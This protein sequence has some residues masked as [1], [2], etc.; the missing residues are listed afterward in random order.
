M[1]S[2]H[3]RQVPKPLLF[4]ITTPFWQNFASIWTILAPD[5]Q[6]KYPRQTSCLSGAVWKV[7]SRGSIRYSPLDLWQ[8]PLLAFTIDIIDNIE[9]QETSA[10]GDEHGT[11]DNLVLN[12]ERH[13]LHDDHDQSDQRQYQP[14]FK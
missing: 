2:A 12:I 10:G 5:P 11:E 1:V 6:K 7:I 9:H 14:P 13:R 4:A 8:F 3:G